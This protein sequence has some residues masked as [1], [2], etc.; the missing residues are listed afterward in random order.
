M[1]H[2]YLKS[3][4]L[5]IF[6]L[7]C[8]K[9]NAYDCQVGD[10]YYNL[11]NTNNTASVTY[12]YYDSSSNKTAYSG[13][14]II[15][16]S[17]T[18]NGTLYSVTGIETN[19]FSYCSGLTSID[20]P[21]SVTSIGQS[22]FSYCSGLTSVV[23]P[24]N[25]TIIGQYAFNYCSG[26]TSVVIPPSVTSIEQSAFF[27]CSGLTSIDIPSSV[28]SIG[29]SAFSG[30]S[31]LTSIVVESGNSVYDSR[32]NCNAI[33]RTSSNTLTAGCK[34]TMI[35]SSVTSIGQSA[36]SG[37]SGLTS[38]V[39]PSSVTSIEQSAFRGCS[40]L[41]SIDIPSSVT[42]IGKY[43]FR[44]CRGLTSVVIPSSVTSIGN[45]AF[46]E[47]SGLTSVVIPSSVTSIGNDAF[48]GCSGLTSVVIPSSVTS[49]GNYAF[50]GCRG[51][52]SIV[53]ESGNSVYDSRNNCNAIIH[54]T[55]NTLIA[56]CK[57]TM[58]PS[59]VTRIWEYAF[60]GCSGLTYVVIPSSV[61]SIG[62][63]AFTGCSGLI[64]VTSYITKVFETGE[65][66]F[67]DCNNAN[68]YVPIGLVNTFR[69][70]AD[71]KRFINIEE[72]PDVASLAMSCN[73]KGKVLVNGSTLF[74]NDLGEVNVNYEDD[75]TFIFQPN[76]NC[77]LR[78]VLIDGLDVTLSVENNQLTTKVH[79]G[80]KMIVIF[81]K[82]GSDVN[83]DGRVDISDVVALVNVILGQ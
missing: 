41:T 40:G 46:Y 55:S 75:N 82:T 69:S 38:I 66:A 78:Q 6:S 30:C 12:L 29:Q 16:S 77:E 1:K 14:V 25:V 57:N 48:Y 54:T 22:A 70:T 21:S 15:P 59:S 50:R 28:T 3:I 32:N 61:T 35:P 58:I 27:G 67:S 52:T 60:W 20:I 76:D 83:G 18:Y 9:A 7:L 79:V 10:I 47:C 71:W 5:G 42:S 63:Y 8:I 49:I 43:V 4:I 36:F 23:I 19:A 13:S 74:K 24:S 64:S 53:V 72:I 56:G 11:N 39:I 62:K 31:G 17:I 81:D 44:G 80:S 33:I 68:L 73:N 34:N 26:L 2:L 37:C 65:N 51:L 45:D